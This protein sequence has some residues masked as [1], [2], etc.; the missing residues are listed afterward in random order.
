M[1]HSQQFRETRLPAPTQGQPEAGALNRPN[2]TAPLSE[3]AFCEQMGRLAEWLADFRRPNAFTPDGSH[4]YIE[5]AFSFLW[6]KGLLTFGAPGNCKEAA[7]Q[8]MRG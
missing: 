8:V 5:Q 3:A 4:T 1:L 7:K 6:K 2:G